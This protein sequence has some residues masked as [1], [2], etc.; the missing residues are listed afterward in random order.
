MDSVWYGVGCRLEHRDM[1][2]QVDCTHDVQKLKSVKPG[3]S[4]GNDFKGAKVLFR[5]FV[6][7]LSGVKELHFD[8]HMRAYGKF[9]SQISLG[10]SQDLEA[11]L[12]GLDLFFQ[13]N[14][15]LV[16]VNSEVMSSRGSEVSFRLNRD[17]RVVS[18]VTKKGEIPV[19]VFSA[20]L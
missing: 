7:K 10:I 3:T 2:D 1:E 8:K 11:R 6:Q 17:V 5:K 14:M 18:F 4:L 15:Q 20:L 16:K 12:S 19:V 13:F 9:G